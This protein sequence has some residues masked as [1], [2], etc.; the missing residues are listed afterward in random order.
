[1]NER[2]LSMTKK[3]YPKSETTRNTLLLTAEDLFTRKGYH[4][5]SMRDIADGAGL[6]LGGIYNHFPDKEAL[7]FERNPLLIMLESLQAP[8]EASG[9]HGFIRY[10]IRQFVAAYEVNPHLLNLM[11]IEVVEFDAKHVPILFER[12]TPMVQH[13]TEQL[14]A[15]EPD[16]RITEPILLFRSML[17]VVFS[18]FITGKMIKPL[19]IS[20]EQSG[21]LDD[22]IDLYLKGAMR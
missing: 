5:T 1:M 16:L 21:T 18:Y 3:T 8:I 2:S 10:V 19:N 9:E 12:L 6:A 4:S 14:I 13:I 7:L 15:R 22:F 11:L 17:G 20:A